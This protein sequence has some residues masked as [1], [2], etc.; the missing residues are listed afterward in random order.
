MTRI[1]IFLGTAMSLID[2]MFAMQNQ[3]LLDNGEYMVIHVDMMTYSPREAR[4]YLWK[5]D[6]YENLNNCLEPKDFLKRARSLM[7]VV[8]TPP[9]QN[10][11][12]FTKKVREYSSKEPFNFVIPELLKKYEKYVSI[13]AAY[14]YDSVKLY[15]RALDQLLRDQPER[16][17]DEIVR[18]GT[19]IIDTIIKN[20][21]YQSVSGATIKL[22]KFG[23]SEGN[24]SVLALKKD[25]FRMDNF[26]CDYQMK[27]VGQFQQGETLV[28]I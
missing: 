12:E 14:L 23:D 27:P 16:T 3:R 21:T 2:M 15:A 26:S 8:S 20:H 11:E 5:P 9:T 17:L 24:F 19:Q 18:N 6:H 10:Y 1:Y 28:S 13:H 25:Y 7:V 22:D 4:K